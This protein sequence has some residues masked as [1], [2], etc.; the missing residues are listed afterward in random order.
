[1]ANGTAHNN[2]HATTANGQANRLNRAGNGNKGYKARFGRGM[3]GGTYGTRSAARPSR[4]AAPT[5]TKANI[6]AT[7][8]TT[9]DLPTAPN[10]HLPAPRLVR[11]R[12]KK[13]LRPLRDKLGVA[14]RRSV[15]LVPIETAEAA[16]FLER[17]ITVVAKLSGR[18]SCVAR[19]TGPQRTAPFAI[20]KLRP[21]R[22]VANTKGPT[23]GQGG[24]V[25]CAVKRDTVPLFV[26]A[27]Q[28]IRPQRR[29]LT[30]Q[31]TSG[32][33]LGQAAS[34]CRASLSGP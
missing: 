13:G 10:R 5:R 24:N 34:F 2:N 32:R 20:D 27:S 12:I 14:L 22:G 25:S 1:M 28:T 11:P 19:L 16:P 33:P 30:S 9:K 17:L 26:L 8:A 18:F 15:T 4:A 29:P 21:F 6:I 23:R 7:K 3:E 31:R